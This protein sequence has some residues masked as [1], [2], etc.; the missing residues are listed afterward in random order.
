MRNRIDHWCTVEPGNPNPGPTV[1]VGNSAKPRFPLER[2]TLGL[3]FPCPH[4]T[5]VMDSLYLTLVNRY[6]THGQHT[7][8]EISLTSICIDC[9]GLCH[10]AYY[11]AMIEWC[12]I[13][14]NPMSEPFCMIINATMKSK[15][16]QE[17]GSNKS[18]RC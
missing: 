18:F 15:G 9:I 6:L 8:R 7:I 17:K 2:W 14:E 3:G 1:P 13:R 16:M 4:L 5:P 10:K 11:T 12:K